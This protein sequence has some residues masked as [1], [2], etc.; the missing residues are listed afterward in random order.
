MAWK[1]THRWIM[2]LGRASRMWV[3]EDENASIEMTLT[4]QQDSASIR[5]KYRS[6][7]AFAPHSRAEMDI[8]ISY[9]DLKELVYAGED[10]LAEH[11]DVVKPT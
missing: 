7:G 3:E 1:S 2:V 11:T 4:D 10:I 8:R 9:E 5:L 6:K